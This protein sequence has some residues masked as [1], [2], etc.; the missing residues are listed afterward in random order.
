MIKGK[1]Y[2]LSLYSCCLI[3]ACVCVCVLGNIA[4]LRINKAESD[5]TELELFKSEP[6]VLKT[7]KL[8]IIVIIV[9]VG[10]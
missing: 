1:K 10:H 8:I 5:W 2:E 4:F 3:H 7:T 6:A 9:V